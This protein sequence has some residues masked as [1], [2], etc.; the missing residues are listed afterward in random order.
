MLA[1]KTPNLT[2][3]L[4]PIKHL[5]E[6][7]TRSW[8]AAQVERA[9]REGPFAITAELT[10]ALAQLL[11]SL[12]P[13]NRKFYPLAPSYLGMCRDIRAGKWQHNGETVIVAD[14][15]EL[16]DGTHRCNAVVE[17]GIAITTQMTF[18]VGRETR[19]SVDMGI[20]RTVAHHL[21]MRGH[22][23]CNV[24][25]HAG[26]LILGFERTNRFT[27]LNAELRP[28][29]SEI[30]AFIESRDVLPHL[31]FGSGVARKFMLSKGLMVALHYQFA[32]LDRAMADTFFD[33]VRDGVLGGEGLKNGPLYKLREMLITRKSRKLTDSEIAE[34]TI[35]AWNAWRRRRSAR[36][37]I[38]GNP[39]PIPE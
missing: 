1:R 11:L 36:S 7:G 12:N 19:S 4:F 32:S 23:D 28:T 34:A 27:K 33:A 9:R 26:A 31:S 14:T 21:E 30:I 5:S 20:K 3:P 6:Q 8:F 10:P 17:T 29:A 24:L 25:A 2:A 16:N 38:G 22:H 39:F 35:N 37:L 15:S 18:G 13:N